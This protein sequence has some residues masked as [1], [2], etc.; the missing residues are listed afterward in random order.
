MTMQPTATPGPAQLLF[1]P[2]PRLGWTF[3]SR[4]DLVT[5]YSEPPPDPQAIGREAANRVA[6]AQQSW[7]RARKWG[8]RPSLIVAF[9]LIA[10]AGCAH[11]ISSSAPFGTT[12]ITALV[13][14]APGTGWA[15]WRYAQ[16]NLAKDADPRRHYDASHQAWQERASAWERAELERLADV[17][18]WGSADSPS[19]RT[20]VFGGT[21]NGWRSLLTVHGAS[22][23]S[24]RPL[25]VADLTG[26]DV[27]SELV[28][29][30]GGT[31]IGVAQYVLPRDLDRCGL[32]SGLSPQQLADAL[33]EAIHAGPA[34]TARAD[35][36]IDVRVLEQLA[37][38]L[39]AGGITPVR[40]AVAVQ[41]ALGRPVPPGVLS[42]SET[43]LI[44]G[45]VF[46]DGYKAQIGANLVRLDAFLSDLARY[47]SGGG[48]VPP[49]AYCTV[50]AAE[51]AARSARIELTAALVVQWLTV[52]VAA[53]GPGAPAV[54]VAGADELTRHHLE[55]LADACDTS[56][57][58]LTLLLRHLRDDAVSVIG[59]GATAFMRL[60]NHREAEQAAS[61][62]GRHHRFVL[63]SF[64]ATQGGDRT[65]TH[66]TTQT[67][68]SNETRGF[69]G[70]GAFSG[71]ASRSQDY[72]RNYSYS[73]EESVSEGTNWS[74]ARGTQRVYEYAVEPNVLQNLP[75]DALLLVRRGN[76]PGMQS[77][78]CDPAIVTLP[79]FSTAPP[80]P[81]EAAPP[82]DA[83][84][85]PP[86]LSFTE[87]E[88]AEPAEAEKPPWW[89]IA[90]PPDQRW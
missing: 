90:K 68:G 42:A 55:R 7:D 74:D 18:E 71:G 78:E 58:P 45:S 56:G 81:A 9:I 17:P 26:Q 6:A 41:A 34:G 4:R 27:A 87:Y 38:V 5:P 3:R 47:G 69:R 53:Y 35:R 54:I 25:L 70:D 30:A 75:D 1:T 14:A 10:L 60:G 22:V 88:Q 64:T 49:M 32:L 83:I 20:D 12:F 63:S 36:A 16:L 86:D 2:G 37:S 84:E 19:G 89:E 65:V 76:G 62:I 85:P 79:G 82:V 28:A 13:L 46:G 29:L 43:D 50:L 61:F 33:A 66:G 72:S 52:Q 31:D 73:T 48:A 23:L 51:P 40:L 24:T 11:V 15:I 8:L 44:Q 67:W 59:G 21:L 80:A 77:V 39:T 57:V